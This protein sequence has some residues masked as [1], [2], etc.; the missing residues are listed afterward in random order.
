M[1]VTTQEWRDNSLSAEKLLGGKIHLVK[2]DT[3]FEVNL[4]VAGIVVVSSSL[5]VEGSHKEIYDDQNNL[6]RAAL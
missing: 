1:F 6:V 3:V 5:I 4:D 2:E